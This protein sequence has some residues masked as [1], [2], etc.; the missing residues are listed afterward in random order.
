MPKQ[1]HSVFESPV[2]LRYDGLSQT[3]TRSISY[4]DDIHGPT[5]VRVR[6]HLPPFVLPSYWQEYR[7]SEKDVYKL[8]DYLP[9]RLLWLSCLVHGSDVQAGCLKPSFA[10]VDEVLISYRLLAIR[11]LISS[12]QFSF[13]S[14]TPVLDTTSPASLEHIPPLPAQ[15][16]DESLISN[17]TKLLHPRLRAFEICKIRGLFPWQSKLYLPRKLEDDAIYLQRATPFENYERSNKRQKYGCA[18]IPFV[19]QT[20]DDSKL[21]ALCEDGLLLSPRQ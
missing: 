12:L 4:T 10:R 15:E 6:T 5:K 1:A 16:I 21:Y 18:T 3:S 2:E 9:A 20:P 17:I 11:T 19:V 14:K 13:L 8:A 7:L